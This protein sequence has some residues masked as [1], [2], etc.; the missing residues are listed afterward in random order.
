M[1]ILRVA[2]FILCS[3][4]NAVSAT[5]L[6]NLSLS[7]RY[8]KNSCAVVRIEGPNDSGTGFFVN[9]SGLLVT[10]AHVLFDRSFTKQGNDY[11]ITIALHWPL[12]VVFQNGQKRTME[13]PTLGQRDLENAIFDVAAINTGLKTDCFIALGKSDDVRVGDPVISI[14]FP[15]SATSGVLYAGFLSAKHNHVP[16]VIGP[17]KDTTDFRSV[18][19]DIFRVQMPVTAGASGSPVIDDNNKVVAVVSEIPVVWTTE[20]SGFIHAVQSGGT[21]SIV[22]SGFN[23]TAILAQLALIV[24]E[25]E[26]PGAGL[27]V[28]ISY[29]RLPPATQS[30]KP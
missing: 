24:K 4:S 6:P 9:S 22:M 26:S 17:V 10:A 23:T 27:A 5:D 12:N 29:L 3:C 19:R 16:T 7:E 25:F 14:G 15:G 30:P 20:L 1:R 18:S 2:G 11:P 13:K 28:P 21:G 8:A